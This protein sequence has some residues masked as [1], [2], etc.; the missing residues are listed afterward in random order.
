MNE[1]IAR[2]EA[3]ASHLRKRGKLL[4][5]LSVERCI[6]ILRSVK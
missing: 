4:Q 2:L 1:A 5:V 3:C 6:T